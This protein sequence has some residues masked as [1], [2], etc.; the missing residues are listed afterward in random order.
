MWIMLG[1]T[2]LKATIGTAV[3]LLALDVALYFAEKKARKE[4]LK[5]NARK[6]MGDDV[7]VEQIGR[8]FYVVM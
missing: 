4:E 2:I 3:T 7:E 6:M 8:D 1:K 5:E